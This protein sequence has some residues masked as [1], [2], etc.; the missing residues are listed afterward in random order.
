MESNE[1]TIGLD[2]INARVGINITSEQVAKLLT[3]MQ[4][5]VKNATA[6]S[7]TVVAPPTRSDILHA[8]DIMEDVAIAFGIN[9]IPRT[10][11]KTST[12]G[13]KDP[14][15]NLTDLLRLELANSGYTEVLTLILVRM[16]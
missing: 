5:N 4:L 14:L 12:V 13:K 1:F 3:R 2:Y 16:A 9:N 10:S 7:L 15:N 11:A 8:C 6:T